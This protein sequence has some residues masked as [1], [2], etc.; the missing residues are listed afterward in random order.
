MKYRTQIWGGVILLFLLLVSIPVTGAD[1]YTVRTTVDGAPSLSPV[2]PEFTSFL[3]DSRAARLD[4]NSETTSTLGLVPST[5]DLSFSR[6]IQISDMGGVSSQVNQYSEIVSSLSD[7][8]QTYGAVSATTLPGTFDLRT[9]GKVTS[10]K[11]QGQCGS[12][13]A[14]STFA[15]LESILLPGESWDFSENNL[16]NTHGY[17][18]TSCQGGNAMMATAYLA[19]WSGALT[20]SSDPYSTVSKSATSIT[21]PNSD[22]VKHV[23]EVL[24]I[25]GRGSSLDNTNIK[26]ALY[27]KGAV[28]STIRWE[29]SSYR[30]SS[31]SYYYKG[32]SG[33]NHAI[34]IIGWDDSYDR[35]K[36][37]SQPPGNGAFI[38]KNSWGSN[39]GEG[40]Y[41]YVSYYDTVIGEDNAVF[42][43]EESDNYYHIYQYDP[44][45]WVV[46]YG[47]NSET[48]YFANIFTAQSEEDLSAVSFYTAAPNS[49]YQL[50]VYK[51]VSGTPVSG[52]ALVSQ[53]GT[54][55]VSGYH[56]IPLSSAV[57]LQKGEKFSIVI[58]LT[59][60]DY[61]Y[62]V[63]IEYPL[64]GFSSGARATSGQSYVSSSG[65]LWYDL[66]TIYPNSNVC[67]K[68]FT[69][70]AS[71]STADTP[72][73]TPS[74]TTTPTPTTTTSAADTKSPTVTLTSP[75]A[76][77][78]V[79]PGSTVKVIWSATD[80]KGVSGVDIAVSK[81]KGSTWTTVAMNLAKTGTYTLTVP[82][83]VSGTFMIRVTAR[84]SAGNE[85]SSTRSCIVR[86][87]TLST[88][89]VRTTTTTTTPVPTTI[90]LDRTSRITEFLSR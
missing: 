57:R 30:S 89:T 41:F 90:A 44:L 9:Q 40:G 14:F 27:E 61:K 34:T 81:D 31:A 39:W 4:F 60:P 3:Y 29:E 18:L 67:I 17:D 37:T 26:R 78:S 43:S 77:S 24:Y 74:A 55:S 71:G 32:S 16:R 76:F 58:K 62:P 53:S 59:T 1:D 33:A 10:V 11:E 47:E 20:E 19:R 12:C 79:T 22:S 50:F 83:D 51:G 68:A 85:G 75:R 54:I 25:P 64:S 65:T 63:A 21:Y 48:E 82:Q 28:Y 23:Q 13:W 2:N 46:S 84:D 66:S 72:T 42:T 49:K 69:T 87:S 7:R 88:T 8:G 5:V 86:A 73:S 56:T 52:S 45:G 6:G 80:N 38:V 35:S 70:S 15:S 36:F